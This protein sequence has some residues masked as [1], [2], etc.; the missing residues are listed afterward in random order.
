V[1]EKFVPIFG[2]FVVLQEEVG[3]VASRME[4]NLSKLMKTL[5]SSVD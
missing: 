4:G 1:A 5:R 3:E 2:C